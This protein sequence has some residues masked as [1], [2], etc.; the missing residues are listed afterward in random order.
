M[1]RKAQTSQT[2]PKIISYGS[3]SRN[4]PRSDKNESSSMFFHIKFRTCDQ[5]MIMKSTASNRSRNERS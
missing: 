1:D 5:R 4:L 2:W 3:C